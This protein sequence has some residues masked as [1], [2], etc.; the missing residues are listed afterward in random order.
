MT[1]EQGQILPF[2]K[3]KKTGGRKA[4][5]PNKRTIER[6][7]ALQA[8]RASGKDPISFF[9]D[10]LANED[11][12]IELRFQA[13]KEL[14]PYMHPRLS[15]VEAVNG[16]KTHEQRLDE[17]TRMIAE[18]DVEEAEDTAPLPPIPA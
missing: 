18:H 13:A 10:L 16:A 4:G 3:R 9:A 6:R 7:T 11:L 1:D 12:P 15:A 5:T 14:A 8:I 17:L 2:R